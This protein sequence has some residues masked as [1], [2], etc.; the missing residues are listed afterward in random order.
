MSSSTDPLWLALSPAR[1]NELLEKY[2]NTNVG[3]DWYDYSYED[4]V[5]ELKKI[6]IEVDTKH[7]R[8]YAIHFSGFSSQGDGACFEGYVNDW[9]KLLTELDQVRF[10]PHQNGW[11]FRCTTVG[12]YCHSNTMAF[13]GLMEPECNPYDEDDELLQHEAWALT[14]ISEK[15][16]DVLWDKIEAKFKDLA[17]KLYADLEAEYDY[18]TDD[19]QV[20][21]Y[22][23]EYAA[24]ELVEEEE[25]TA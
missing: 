4:F 20:I 23:L 24:D 11:S 18:Q 19:E 15:E 13:D 6:G 22:I 3:F 2:R 14:H 21:E 5:S 25:E 17:D 12:N 10:I 7:G 9:P 16:L 1:R 8:D